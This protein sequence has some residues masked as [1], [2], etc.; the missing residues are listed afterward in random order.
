MMASRKFTLSILLA[1]VLTVAFGAELFATESRVEAMGGIGLYIRDN[2]NV[3]IFPGTFADYPKQFLAEMRTK[4]MKSMWS[5]GVHVPFGDDAVFA[6]YMH[7]PTHA[8]IPDGIVDYVDFDWATEAYYGRPLSDYNFGVGLSVSLD[9][10]TTPDMT[11]K[12]DEYKESATFVGVSAGISNDMMDLGVMFELPS[13]K[14]EDPDWDSDNEFSAIGFGAVGRY[15][16][17]EDDKM[18]VPAVAVHYGS[19]KHEFGDAEVDYTDIMFTLGIVL[20]HMINDDNRLILGIEPL[21][22]SSETEEVKDG[23]KTTETIM[24]VPSLIVAIESE[25]TSWLT[26]RIGARET[27]NYDKTKVEPATGDEYEMSSFGADFMYNMGFAIAVGD[28]TFDAIFNEALFFEGPNFVTGGMADWAY[29]I[30]MTYN[31]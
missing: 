24:G 26:G 17:G 6:A 29:K 3:F 2:S 30:S 13:A 25:I 21:R 9:S 20:D 14:A 23:E 28:F 16:T 1:V 8:L 11:P 7:R 27:F 15:F 22:Y 12:D 10:Y 31:Y 19:G 4:N 18:I 5:G